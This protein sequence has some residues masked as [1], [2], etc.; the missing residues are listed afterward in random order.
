[1]KGR[2]EALLRQHP[3]LGAQTPDTLMAA[4]QDGQLAPR[5]SRR[6]ISGVIADIRRWKSAGV[7]VGPIAVNAAPADFVKGDF[8]EY[9]LEQ[10]SRAQ[11]PFNA[12]QLEVTETVF[13]DAELSAWRRL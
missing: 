8:A 6:I 7:E 3:E 4:F 2:Y 1:M 13:L 12:V 11:L 9:L 5:L 10:L